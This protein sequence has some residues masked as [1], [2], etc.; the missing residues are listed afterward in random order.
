MRFVRYSE[1]KEINDLLE[2]KALDLD[3]VIVSVRQIID[4]VRCNR[5]SALV[6]CTKR[7]DGFDLSKENIKVPVKDIKDAYSKVGGELVAALKHAHRNITRFHEE[8]MK[9]IPD[10]WSV[11]IEGG[12]NVGEKITP[13]HDVGAYIPGGRASYVSTVL[14]ACIPARVAGSKRIVVVSPPPVSDSILVAADICG[15]DEIYRVG[16]AQA[17][18]ALAYGTQSIPSVDKII[19]PG[20]VYVL[21]A[22]MLVYGKV[23]IDMPAGPSEALILADDTANVSFIAADMLAQAE[24]DPNAQCIIVT[25]SES[26]AEGVCEEISGQLGLIKSKET[27]EQSLKNAVIVLTN[28]IF[29]SIEFA[30]MYAAEHLEIMT[31]EPEVTFGKITN[32]GAIFLGEY[33]PIAAGDYVSGGNH[34]LPTAGSARFSSELNVRDFLK[35]SSVQKITKE[36]LNNLLKTIDALSS[37]EGFDAHNRSANIRFM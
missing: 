31:K 19:G 17:I 12:V 1:K 20:N 13:I 10:D 30:N 11:E 33:S 22:K 18:A 28:S 26:V 36:G 23:D 3:E 2:R 34:I 6:D 15:V 5:D 8:Q 32:A 9:H 16:G 35:T 29:E 21:A 4:D 14:M 37:S 27:A 24:H 25:D 7:F